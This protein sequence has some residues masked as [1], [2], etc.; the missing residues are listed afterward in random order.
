MQEDIILGRVSLEDLVG[1]IR[2]YFRSVTIILTCSCEVLYEGRASSRASN[3]RRLIILKE[4]GTVI[5]HEGRGV[6]PINWQPTASVSVRYVSN[7]DYVELVALRGRPREVLRILIKDPPTLLLTKL[8]EGKFL[9]TGTEDDLINYIALN[10]SVIEEGSTLVAREVLTPHGRVDVVLRDIRGDLI[11]VECKRG[12]ADIDAAY[13]LLR[14]V[15]YYRGLGVVV[16]GVLA[17]PSITPQ[18]LNF[19][20]KNG[21]RYVKVS[22]QISGKSL[23]S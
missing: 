19:L 20:I 9:L 4:D 1:I 5:V 2:K 3:A 23:I 15:T 11:V 10:P 7:G 22:P 21:L 13:Q 6:E 14:Y 8:G 17:S 16:R 18:A 12:V